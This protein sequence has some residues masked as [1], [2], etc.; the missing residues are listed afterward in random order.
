[1]ENASALR[2][3]NTPYVKL[4]QHLDR[5]P[6]GF[7]PSRNGADIRLLK[8]IFTPKEAEVATC[9]NHLG[10]SLD[11]IF[12]R[13]AHLVESKR[14]LEKHLTSILKKGGLEFRLEKGQRLYANTPLVVGMYELQ[15]ERLSPEFIQ[16]FKAY[17]SEKRYGISF[18]ATKLPQMRTI[19]IGKSITPK[20]PVADFDQIN[21]LLET[22]SDPF[23]ILPC[24]CRRKKSLQGEPCQQTDRTETCMAMGGVA[25][26][27]LEMEIG[28]E[29]SRNDAMD[30]I[31]EN[32]KEG[33]VLQPGNTQDIELLC[34]CC[35]CCCSMLG[36]QKELPRPLDFWASNFQASIDPNCCVGCGKCSIHCQ[37]QAITLAKLSKKQ[38][39]E[40]RPKPHLNHHRCIACGNCVPACPTGALSLIPCVSQIRPPKN[41]EELNI[42]LLKEKKNKLAPI[43]VIGKLAKGIALTGDLN[44]LRKKG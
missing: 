19:P 38:S 35:G 25:Q 43:K 17:T 11:M 22:A 16:D 14:E 26:T 39:K 4:Q 13:A 2:N 7:P 15:L 34:S 21:T 24:I 6:V 28:R 33:L 27:L 36:L 9:L 29:I 41:R 12:K 31:C 18:L 5:Q 10:Q 37:T 3:D 42:I 32:Q 8:H 40:D 20:L 44:L 1:M 30:I 23:V